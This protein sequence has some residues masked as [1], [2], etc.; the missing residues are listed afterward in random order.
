[1][2]VRELIRKEERGE[3]IRLKEKMTKGIVEEVRMKIRKGG[4]CRKK[5]GQNK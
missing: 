5:K 2:K 3:K 4:G 1:M